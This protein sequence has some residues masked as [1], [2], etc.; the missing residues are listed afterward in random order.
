MGAVFA[1]EILDVPSPHVRLLSIGE[2]P[3]K[4]NQLTLEA[5]ELLA[6]SELDFRGNTES[7]LLLEGGGCHGH[8]W[9][10]GAALRRGLAAVPADISR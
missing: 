6:E 9:W 4:G 10:L 8:D 2:E 3:A 5:H 7:R 1:E